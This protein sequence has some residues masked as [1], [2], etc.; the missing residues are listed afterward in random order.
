MKNDPPFSFVGSKFFVS[1]F[2]VIL[3]NI[4]LLSSLNFNFINLFSPPDFSGKSFSAEA[5]VIQTSVFCSS[6]MAT[7]TTS[8]IVTCAD[9]NYTP[10]CFGDPNFQSLECCRTM[11][12][13]LDCRPD[14]AFVCS[15]NTTSSTTSTTS[16]TTTSTS[17]TSSGSTGALCSTGTFCSNG[18][19]P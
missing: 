8:G 3:L 19:I 4:P 16:S 6:N 9:P 15:T 11:G 14:I 13:S 12:I 18:Y 17:T 1:L 7:C 5:Q 10:T 2:L